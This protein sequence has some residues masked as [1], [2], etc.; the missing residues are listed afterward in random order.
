MAHKMAKPCAID[1]ETIASVLTTLLMSNSPNS[2][3]RELRSGSGAG[4]RELLNDSTEFATLTSLEGSQKNE[5]DRRA[6]RAV[7]TR[8]WH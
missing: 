5:A 2:L 7:R 1:A 8:R 4:G 6:T 3:Q